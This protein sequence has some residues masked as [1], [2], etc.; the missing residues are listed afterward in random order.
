MM[1]GER[2]RKK[3]HS[4][5]SHLIGPLSDSDLVSYRICQQTPVLRIFET[6]DLPLQRGD[7]TSQHA[8][9]VRSRQL[10]EIASLMDESVSDQPTLKRFSRYNQSMHSRPPSH[11]CNIQPGSSQQQ[12]PH[13]CSKIS[14]R[15]KTGFF[16]GN[17]TLRSKKEQKMRPS[18]HDITVIQ[19]GK[20]LTNLAATDSSLVSAD[21]TRLS[22]PL[23]FQEHFHYDQCYRVNSPGS[24]HNDYLVSINDHRVLPT[25]HRKNFISYF[26]QFFVHD[27]SFLSDKFYDESKRESIRTPE[28]IVQTAI[29]PSQFA[30]VSENFNQFSTKDPSVATRQ[31]GGIIP[32]GLAACNN[33]NQFPFFDMFLQFRESA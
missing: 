8:I 30:L 16:S 32:V 5:S 24:I 2:N 3:S 33:W 22:F 21:A 27:T 31:L 10:S 6:D 12:Q 4:I 25:P 14:G 11:T 23:P 18:V 9:M 15:L 17:W 13:T 26:Q 20:S 29:A 1:S 19:T 7:F 28:E